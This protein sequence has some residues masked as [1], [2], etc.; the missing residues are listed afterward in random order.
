MRGFLLLFLMHMEQF[1]LVGY[2]PEFQFYID[3]LQ[4]NARLTA[5]VELN[6]DLNPEWLDRSTHNVYSSIDTFLLN[7][8]NAELVLVCSPVGLHAEHII[9]SLQAGKDVICSSPL[10]L[11][12]AAA[13]QI[14]ETQKFCRRKLYIIKP[15]RFVPELEKLKEKINSGGLGKI[16]SFFI[17]CMNS[18]LNDPFSQNAEKYPGGGLLY[19]DFATSMDALTWLF[20]NVEDTKGTATVLNPATGAEGSGEAFITTSE[21][22]KGSI[23]WG[24]GSD[25]VLVM[26][27]AEKEIINLKGKTIRDLANEED[28]QNQHYKISLNGNGNKIHFNKELEAIDIFLSSNNSSETNVFEELPLIASIEKIYPTLTIKDHP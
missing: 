18:F 17:Q 24:F 2:H 19:S 16:D 27:W 8:I 20:G 22:F 11:T 13:W 10:C 7:E 5:F 28:R 4:K 23:K 12:S 9:K 15:A 6:E 21:K 3:H 14:I 1:A 25:M 26:I